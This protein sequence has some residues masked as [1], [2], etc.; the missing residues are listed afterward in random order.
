MVSLTNMKTE[1]PQDPY[2]ES[3]NALLTEMKEDHKSWHDKLPSCIRRFS[4]IQMSKFPKAAY[5]FNAIQ[6]EFQ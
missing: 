4:I 6:S 3:Y 1:Q 2:S 5:K